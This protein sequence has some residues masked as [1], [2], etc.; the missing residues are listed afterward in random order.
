M[1]WIPLVNWILIGYSLFILLRSFLIALVPSKCQTTL[2][3][4]RVCENERGGEDETELI[5]VEVD[6]VAT[7]LSCEQEK[8][9]P[10]RDL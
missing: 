5:E 2:A 1:G 3:D 6:D 4:E 10:P 9:L 7:I 8:R